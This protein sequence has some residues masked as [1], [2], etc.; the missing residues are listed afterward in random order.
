[1]AFEPVPQNANALRANAAANGF[2]NITTVQAGVSDE[3]GYLEL[4]DNGP[5]SIRYPAEPRAPARSNSTTMPIPLSGSSKIDVEGFEPKVLSGARK[6]L[7]ANRP[8][9]L[10][11]F[12]AWTLIFQHCMLMTFAEFIWSHFE[13]L[14]EFHADTEQP[15]SATPADFLHSKMMLIIVFPISFCA[16]AWQCR[17]RSR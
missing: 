12:N 16:R 17:R 10:M 7:L 14:G 8:L 3:H 15:R 11:E 1:M 13:V 2:A 6:L 9:V 5:W 4:T